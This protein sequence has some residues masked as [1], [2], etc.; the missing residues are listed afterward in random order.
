MRSKKMFPE[1]VMD[2]IIETWFSFAMA[3]YEKS[4]VSIFQ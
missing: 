1:K 2:K 4:S 3:W